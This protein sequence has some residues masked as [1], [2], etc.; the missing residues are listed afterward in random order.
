MGDPVIPRLIGLVLADLLR[1]RERSGSKHDKHSSE[2]QMSDHRFFLIAGAVR[3]T[4]EVVA[5]IN[6]EWFAGRGQLESFD[7]LVVGD[8]LIGLFGFPRVIEVLKMLALKNQ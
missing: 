2:K 4:L 5:A 3:H 8:D 6:L 7:E 1:L